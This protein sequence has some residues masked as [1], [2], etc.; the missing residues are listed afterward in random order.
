MGVLKNYVQY[1]DDGLIGVTGTPE[2]IDRLAM[3][4]KV[5]FE[6]VVEEGDDPSLYLMDH[7]ASLY[8]LDPEGRFLAKFAHGISPEDLAQRL[9]EAVR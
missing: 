9:N 8:L 2:M 3:L 6:K 1:Y 4:Y 7:S 5:R